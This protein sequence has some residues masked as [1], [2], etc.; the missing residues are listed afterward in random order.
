MSEPVKNLLFAQFVGNVWNS[1]NQSVAG[2]AVF[3]A[4]SVVLQPNKLAASKRARRATII[5]FDKLS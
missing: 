3:F 2:R 5:F 1:Q 4:V